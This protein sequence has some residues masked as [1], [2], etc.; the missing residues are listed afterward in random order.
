MPAQYLFVAIVVENIG[1]QELR[2]EGVGWPGVPR[3]VGVNV[4]VS[5]ADFSKIAVLVEFS[6]CGAVCRTKFE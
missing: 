1:G 3:S 4:L 5:L 2:G 6:L